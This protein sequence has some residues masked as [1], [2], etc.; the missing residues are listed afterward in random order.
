MAQKIT[1]ASI[2]IFASSI[3]LLDRDTNVPSAVYNTQ[4]H[5]FPKD[6]HLKK[7]NYR[8]SKNCVNRRLNKDTGT[9]GGVSTK[10]KQ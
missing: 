4:I 8:I 2:I 3:V 7:F 1:I 6:P 10:A 5:L 9:D